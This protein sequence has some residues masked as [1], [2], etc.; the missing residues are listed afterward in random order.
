MKYIK[1]RK[2]PGPS[3]QG[4]PW[5]FGAEVFLK[6]EVRAGAGFEGVIEKV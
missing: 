1:R 3:R 5:C 2:T 4:W 6:W